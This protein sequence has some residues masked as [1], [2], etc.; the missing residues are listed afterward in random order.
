[1]GRLPG[2]DSHTDSDTRRARCSA[3]RS[4][5]A[6]SKFLMILNQGPRIFG[7][8]L[9]T[10]YGA[11]SDPG[12]RNFKL[13]NLQRQQLLEKNLKNIEKLVETGGLAVR[14]PL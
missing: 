11:G 7:L 5:V 12:R 1:M 9:H 6:P 4:A 2:P 10:Y 14:R 13:R 3:E 8:G